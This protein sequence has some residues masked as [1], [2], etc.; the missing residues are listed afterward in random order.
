MQLKSY[1]EANGEPVEFDNTRRGSYYIQ[2]DAINPSVTLLHSNYAN[3]LLTFHI[4]VIILVTFAILRVTPIAYS[5]VLRNTERSKTHSSTLS[6]YWAV[7]FFSCVHCMLVLLLYLFW[8]VMVMAAVSGADW[9]IRLTGTNMRPLIVG[10]VFLPL[11]GLLHLGYCIRV[12]QS[13][14]VYIDVPRVCCCSCRCHCHANQFRC[15]RQS[16]CTKT[17]GTLALW[18]IVM[19]TQSLAFSIIGLG[20]QLAD[21]PLPTIGAL[22][23]LGSSLFLAAMLAAHIVQTTQTPATLNLVT[24]VKLI[25]VVLVGLIFLTIV[26]LSL[27][28]YIAYT[29]SRLDTTAIGSLVAALGSSLILSGAGWLT[30]SRLLETEDENETTQLEEA[31]TSTTTDTD[32]DTDIASIGMKLVRKTVDSV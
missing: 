13:S 19:A 21:E 16:R 1:T 17:I 24:A 6:I 28:V 26:A 3:I 30:K 29:T 31:Q 7:V 20:I 32:N 11:L 8:F 27:V 23:L 4:L 2:A 9:G 18:I 22:S 15:L 25:L 14:V 10:L 12:I 5:K